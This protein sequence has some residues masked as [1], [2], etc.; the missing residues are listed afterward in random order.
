MHCAR[1]QQHKMISILTNFVPIGINW[2]K[3][4]IGCGDRCYFIVCATKIATFSRHIYRY[5]AA[6]VRC[7]FCVRKTKWCPHLKICNWNHLFTF[8]LSTWDKIKLKRYFRKVVES[9]LLRNCYQLF[10]T[11]N[12]RDNSFVASKRGCWRH[13]GVWSLLF[14]D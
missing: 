1:E 11:S 7:L 10:G 14:R 12:V 13:Y 4:I 2:H 5:N 3:I 8:S 6:T 9:N